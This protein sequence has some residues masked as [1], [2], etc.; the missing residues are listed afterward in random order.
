[1]QVG[2][3]PNWGCSAKGKNYDTS[4]KAEV[5]IP[6]EVIRFFN[7]FSSSSPTMVLESILPLT[8]ISTSYLLWGKGRLA[9]NA[10]NNNA[11]YEPIV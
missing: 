11:I 4:R 10:D 8:E 5:S 2:Q 7:S 6:D 9:R 3:D 1:M